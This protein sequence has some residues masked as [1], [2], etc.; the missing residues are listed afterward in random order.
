M[1]SSVNDYFIVWLIFQGKKISLYG[2]RADD[3]KFRNVMISLSYGTFW[4]ALGD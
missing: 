3:Y 1:I 4:E 2:L